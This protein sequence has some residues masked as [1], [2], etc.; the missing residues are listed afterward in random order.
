MKTKKELK[1]KMTEEFSQGGSFSI[2]V[3]HASDAAWDYLVPK[4][5]HPL[6]RP[7]DKRSILLLLGPVSCSLWER[8]FCVRAG[9]CTNKGLIKDPENLLAW[10]EMPPIP[11]ELPEPETVKGLF[12]C[13]IDDIKDA[14]EKMSPAE[15]AKLI[16]ALR[17]H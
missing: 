17:K 16:E 14:V 1:L 11:T 15:K 5:H 3:S 7:D 9:Y 6:D 2:A 13:L 4:L 10:T 8:G 12:E